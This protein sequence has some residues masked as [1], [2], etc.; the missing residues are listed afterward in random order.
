MKQKVETL[1]DEWNLDQ[2]AMKL[3]EERLRT[4]TPTPLDWVI[5]N[6]FERREYD[7]KYG[8]AEYTQTTHCALIDNESDSVARALHNFSIPGLGKFDLRV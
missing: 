5:I 6:R 7:N 1:G 4:V 3:F 2:P 8:K